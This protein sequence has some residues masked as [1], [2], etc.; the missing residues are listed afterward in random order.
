[1]L[2]QGR[3]QLELERV[4]EPAQRRGTEEKL[5]VNEPISRYYPGPIIGKARELFERLDRTVQHTSFE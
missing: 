5:A 1:M 3:V 4:R 2:F